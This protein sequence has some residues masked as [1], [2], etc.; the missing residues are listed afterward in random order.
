M[1]TVPVLGNKIKISVYYEALCP[2]SIDFIR[3]QLSPTYESLK[4]N[5]DVDL[6]PYGKATQTK[7]PSGS[8]DFEC[9]H[10]PNECMGNKVQAC[11]IKLFSNDSAV[12][13]VKCVMSR[14][15]PHESG[16]ACGR[17]LNLDVDA[18]NTCSTGSQGDEYLASLGDRTHSLKPKMTFVP[19]ININDKHDADQQWESLRDLKKVV[20]SAY[21]STD[22]PSSCP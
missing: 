18:L 2:D 20:C 17:Q 15:R 1:T 10:G 9:Q 11:A 13:F 6:I 8:W 4:D 5:L 21:N 14:R 19:W 12:K 22:R 7:T 16:E 3:N